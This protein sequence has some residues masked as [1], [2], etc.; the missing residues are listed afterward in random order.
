M[1][2]VSKFKLGLSLSWQKLVAP[3]HGSLLGLMASFLRIKLRLNFWHSK[4]PMATIYHESCCF[5]VADHVNT[6]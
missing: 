3:I 2:F 5:G 6:L 4:I 1:K